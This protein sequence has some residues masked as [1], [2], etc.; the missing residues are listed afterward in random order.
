VTFNSSQVSL[1]KSSLQKFVFTAND[2]SNLVSW[3]GLLPLTDTLSLDSLLVVPSLNYNLFSVSQ[4]TTVL[5][6]I[7]IF[8]PNSCGFKDIQTRQM[9]GYGIKREMLY[10]L[11]LVSNSSNKLC[12][13]LTVDDSQG[14]KKTFDIW[15]WHR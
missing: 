9:I 7:I 12:H 2:T 15:L 3:E 13:A 11:D 1:I 4:I 5:F 14:E 8:W 10:Y 6:C